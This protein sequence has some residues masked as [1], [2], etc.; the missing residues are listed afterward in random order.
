M[1]AASK[2]F[3]MLNPHSGR[4][5]KL[6]E[7]IEP[8]CN[9]GRFPCT[10]KDSRGSTQ[11][12]IDEHQPRNVISWVIEVDGMCSIKLHET[13]TEFAPALHNSLSTATQP[14]VERRRHD[15]SRAS[16]GGETFV[17]VVEPRAQRKPSCDIELGA[18]RTQ[19][20][21]DAQLHGA[22]GTDP[23][24]QMVDAHL[25]DEHMRLLRNIE[26]GVCEHETRLAQRLDHE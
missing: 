20:A 24:R 18:K 10:K 12:L 6:D 7:L 25:F 2:P 9:R 3:S 19:F 14:R 8:R 16:D 26:M 11:C 21:V 17:P 13:L 23:R 5:I 22:V 1:M 4:H 15:D